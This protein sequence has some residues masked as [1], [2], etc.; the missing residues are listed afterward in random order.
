MYLNFIKRDKRVFVYSG[1]FGI[2]CIVDCWMA[3]RLITGVSYV[4][5]TWNDII[6]CLLMY[7][8]IML[9]YLGL[10][11]IRFNVKL[12]NRYNYACK[13]A[14]EDRYTLIS[15]TFLAESRSYLLA[16]TVAIYSLGA[17]HAFSG[18]TFTLGNVLEMIAVDVALL[19]RIF[20]QPEHFS[21]FMSKE[22]CLL[23]AEC[24]YRTKGKDVLKKIKELE[25]L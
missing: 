13:L 8:I 9:Y 19:S 10:Q 17:A 21:E 20:R 11:G 23:F 24:F 22:Y 4:I 16:A 18:A 14:P 25:K 15:F 6:V 1:Y 2:L 12:P 7:S 3:H 5:P